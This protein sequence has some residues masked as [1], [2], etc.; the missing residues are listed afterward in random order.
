ME[1]VN[2]GEFNLENVYSQS[3]FGFE[4]PQADGSISGCLSIRSNYH[5]GNIHKDNFWDVWQNKFQVYRD[6]RW[7]KTEQCEHC[8]MWRYCQGNGMH[9]RDGNGKL[10]MCQYNMLNE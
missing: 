10:Q 8:K 9:L 3:L 6:R 2:G 5:Q 7:M 1:W 4:V